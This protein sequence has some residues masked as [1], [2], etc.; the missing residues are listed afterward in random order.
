MRATSDTNAARTGDLRMP[1]KFAAFLC[2]I[3]LA[4]VPANAQVSER[5]SELAK[6]YIIIDGHVDAP[7]S[8]AEDGADIAT[9]KNTVDFDYDRAKAGG[10]DA[11]FMSIYVSADFEDKGGAKAR[12]DILIGLMEGIAA[13]HPDKFEIAYSPKDV[14]RIHRAGKIAIT[15]RGRP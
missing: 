7:T 9:G 1:E 5:A 12:A 6:T 2:T 14:R 11:P 4:A 13:Q 3:A 8:I 10:L 15:H